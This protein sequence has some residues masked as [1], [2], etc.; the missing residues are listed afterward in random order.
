MTQQ[1]HAEHC[2]F[3]VPGAAL[4]TLFE[5]AL[6]TASLSCLPTLYPEVA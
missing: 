4:E 1:Q 3:T 2:V 5:A 6:H